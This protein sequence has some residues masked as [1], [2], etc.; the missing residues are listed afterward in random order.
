M[1]PWYTQK[2][3]WPWDNEDE[4]HSREM[5]STGAGRHKKWKEQLQCSRGAACARP[6]Q[7]GHCR[8]YFPRAASRLTSLHTALSR[9]PSHCRGRPLGPNALSSA[10]LTCPWL[11]SSV[12][13]STSPFRSWWLVMT[14][15]PFPWPCPLPVPVPTYS[16]LGSLFLWPPSDL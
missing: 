9:P 13:K 1:C 10:V 2:E 6:S 14:P 5:E 8:L 16:A 7:E 4:N 11:S 15:P 3:T 12:P